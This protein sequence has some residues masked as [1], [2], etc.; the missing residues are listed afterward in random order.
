[1]TAKD[2]RTWWG[3]VSAAVLLRQAPAPTSLR[4]H[5]RV[6]VHVLDEV[7]S[8]LGNTRA[9]CRKCYVHPHVLE[10]AA[11]RLPWPRAQMKVPAGLTA[12]EMAVVRLLENMRRREVRLGRVA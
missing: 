4:G 1:M 11:R 6:E 7:A 9:I 2:F 5:K 12:D 10:A 8:Q 3:T